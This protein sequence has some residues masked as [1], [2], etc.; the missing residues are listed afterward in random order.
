VVTKIPTAVRRVNLG[1]QRFDGL[2]VEVEVKMEIVEV[3]A[4][5]Q[6][7]QHV[8]ALPTNL[9]PNLHPVQ[10]RR[11]EKLCRFERPEQIPAW[12]TGTSFVCKTPSLTFH[13]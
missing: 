4:V 1:G 12:I 9:Q 11:L 13:S 5:D 2:Q 7:I 3:L 10:S 8:V 6:Q